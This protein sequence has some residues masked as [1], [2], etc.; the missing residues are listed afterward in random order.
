[1]EAFSLASITAGVLTGILGNT[2]DR[3]F[4]T[5]FKAFINYLKQGGKPVNHDLQKAL[6]PCFLSALQTIASECLEEQPPPQLVRDRRIYHNLQ[7]Q[8]DTNSL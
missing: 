3:V 7:H 4:L 2:A 5:G 1:M 8:S 6:R